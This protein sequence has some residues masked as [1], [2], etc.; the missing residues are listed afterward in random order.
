[1]AT[2]DSLIFAAK[3]FDYLEARKQELN[4]E[5]VSSFVKGDLDDIKSGEIIGAFGE[6]NKFYEWLQGH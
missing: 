6:I 2:R 5:L 4:T 3:V 1:M